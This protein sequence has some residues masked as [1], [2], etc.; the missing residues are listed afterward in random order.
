MLPQIPSLLRYVAVRR[1][2]SLTSMRGHFHRPLGGYS[3]AAGFHASSRFAASASDPSEQFPILKKITES[4]RVMLQ[5]REFIMLLEKKGI[6]TQGKPPT[7]FEMMQ[8]MKDPEM[9]ESLRKLQEELSAAGI[10]IDMETV[11]AFQKATNK[12]LEDDRKDGGLKE[13]VKS[14]FKKD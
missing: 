4:P 7:F 9:K 10:P 13:K 5:F 6:N 8:I 14:L 3:A 12:G 11:A 1:T 2:A